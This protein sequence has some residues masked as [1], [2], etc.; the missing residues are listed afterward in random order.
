M[1]SHQ[2]RIG[3]RISYDQESCTVRFIGKIPQWSVLAYGVEWDNIRKGKH[4]GILEGVQYFQCQQP[5]AGSFVKSTKKTDSS[6]EFINALKNKYQETNGEIPLIQVSGSKVIENY[7]TEKINAKIS[8]LELLSTVSLDHRYIQDQNIPLSQQLKLSSDKLTNVSILDL[9]YNLISSINSVANLCQGLPSIKELILNGNRFMKGLS[10]DFVCPQLKSLALSNSFLDSSEFDSWSKLFPNIIELV[11]PYNNYSNGDLNF[12][13]FS[14][15]FRLDLSYNC[16]KI[17]PSSFE[18][19]PKLQILC[20]AHNNICKISDSLTELK[21][22]DVS[23]NKITEWD[24][25]DQLGDLYPSITELR[26]RGNYVCFCDDDDVFDSICL[27]RWAG[28]YGL[29]KINGV[30]YSEKETFDSEIFFMGMV[31]SQK[32]PYDMTSKHWNHLLNKHKV[33]PFQTQFIEAGK[34]SSRIIIVF[35][36]INKNN[37]K[38]IRVLKTDSIQKI[39][40]N[41]LRKCKIYDS[42]SFQFTL[43]YYDK[44]LNKKYMM[45]DDYQTLEYYSIENNDM[46]YVEKLN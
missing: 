6:F 30:K 9:S 29:K 21:N 46:L 45:N 18:L 27:A 20:L 24:I 40:G 12:S 25:Y 37:I 5:G 17:M 1:T 23:Y 4:D 44:V 35:V 39:K 26:I 10:T 7:G 19:P 42:D 28:E 16:I 33:F 3:S 41:V 32:I 14:N 11:V 43:S 22:L 2:I 38:K 36:Q 13:T 34:S 15:V 31:S 8:N